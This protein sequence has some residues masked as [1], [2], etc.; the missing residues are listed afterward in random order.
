MDWKIKKLQTFQTSQK[1]HNEVDTVLKG[2]EK[3]LLIC[4]TVLLILVCI[5]I[6]LAAGKPN[7]KK[8]SAAGSPFDFDNWN[9]FLV[10]VFD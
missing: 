2:I 9:R 10:R 8:N 7:D 3:R 5:A 6:I 4:Y 1:S